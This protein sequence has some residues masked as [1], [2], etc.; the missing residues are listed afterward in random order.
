MEEM[1]KIRNLSSDFHSKQKSHSLIMENNKILHKIIEISERKD[2]PAYSTIASHQVPSKK[3]RS[4][5]MFDNPERKRRQKEIFDGNEKLAKK[6]LTKESE[7]DRSK[8]IKSIEEYES[9]K[10]IL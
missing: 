4:V 1:H 5:I 3:N 2:L 6:L 9:R 8:T 10:K 7:F